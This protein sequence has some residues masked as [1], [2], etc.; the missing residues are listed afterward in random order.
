MALSCGA[1]NRPGENLLR[2]VSFWSTP[3]HRNRFGDL[4]TVAAAAITLGTR[5]SFSFRHAHFVDGWK[6]L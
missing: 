4:P 1:R 6:R 5:R 2:V 3:T